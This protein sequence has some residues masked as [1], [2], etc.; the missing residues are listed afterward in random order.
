MSFPIYLDDDSGD[1]AIAE[2]LLRAGEDIIRSTDVGMRG[3]DDHEHLEFAT[4]RGVLITAN[5]SHYWQLHSD[6]LRS[7]RSHAG[8]II[9]HQG[10]YSVGERLRRLRRLLRE[11]TAEEMVERVEWL[12]DWGEP[13]SPS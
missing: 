11:R 1:L 2:N 6:W 5:R 9:I 10:R 3:R 8:I 12:R 7:G 13:E 4:L